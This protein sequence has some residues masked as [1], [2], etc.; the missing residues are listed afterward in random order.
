MKPNEATWQN[1]ILIDTVREGEKAKLPKLFNK[2]FHQ[3]LDSMK[4]NN[5][6]TILVHEKEDISSLE[7]YRPTSLSSKTYI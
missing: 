6:I 5:S 7:N 1:K 3:C 4:W 2:C